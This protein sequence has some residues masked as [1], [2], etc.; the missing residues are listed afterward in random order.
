MKN[1]NRLNKVKI[2]SMI[3]MIK[4]RKFLCAEVMVK[5]TFKEK[6]IDNIRMFVIRK[7]RVTKFDVYQHV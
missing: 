2:K 7:Q 4:Y 6:N 5:Y 3:E 1:N